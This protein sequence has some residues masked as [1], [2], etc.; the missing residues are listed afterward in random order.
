MLNIINDLDC[1]FEDCYRRVNV[2]EY[3]RIKGISPPTASKILTNYQKEG[4]LFK[5]EYRIMPIKIV[6]YS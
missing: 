4:L 2:R 5:E 3:A 1:F 6:K